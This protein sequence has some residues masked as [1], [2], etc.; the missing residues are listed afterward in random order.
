[1]EGTRLGGRL[2]DAEGIG[3]VLKV[4]EADAF[5]DVER[6]KAPITDFFDGPHTIHEVCDRPGMCLTAPLYNIS[7]RHETPYGEDPIE[8]SS[9]NRLRLGDGAQSFVD[10]TETHF[11]FFGGKTDEWLNQD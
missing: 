10:R 8:D 6:I 5:C 7:Y 2:V 9:L 4:K 11:F 1:M 3:L